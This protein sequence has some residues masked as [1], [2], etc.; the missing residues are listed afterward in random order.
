MFDLGGVLM[1]FGGLARL[2][3][4]TGQEDGPELRSKWA[5]SQ[6]LQAF[7]R[8]ECD[9]ATFSAGVVAD[10]NLELTPAEF[11]DEFC[12][13][14][15]GP[16][17]GSVDLLESLHGSI[18]MGCLSNTNPI[19]WQQ[20]LDRW[21]VVGFFD[22][23]FVSHELGIMK[24]DPEIFQ[25]IIGTVDRAPERIMFLDDC[26]D[27][28]EAARSQGMLAAHTRGIEEVR[29]ALSSCLPADSSA[30]RALRAHFARSADD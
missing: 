4:L 12:S 6:W 2:S 23:T 11:V 5:T 17:A 19:H 9:A 20:H 3:E 10:W 24:P 22:W 28:V 18:S 30:G 25:Q 26:E 1:N 27:H 15:A 16:F 14:P 13:W 8:G 21:G 29:N 7:E